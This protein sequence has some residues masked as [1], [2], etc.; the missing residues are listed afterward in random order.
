M[1]NVMAIETVAL[2]DLNSQLVLIDQTQLPNR[3]E[4]RLTGGD[5][6]DIVIQ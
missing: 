5:D 1:E 6:V 2:D 3:V 4:I